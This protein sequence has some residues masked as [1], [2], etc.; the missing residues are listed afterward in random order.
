MLL[1]E[2]RRAKKLTQYDL[3]H[4]SG[5]SQNYISELEQEKHEATETLILKLCIALEVD[6]NTLLGWR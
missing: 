3:A 2:I 6:P 4:L 1:K 5:I